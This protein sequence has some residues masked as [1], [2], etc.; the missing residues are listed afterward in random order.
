[1][2]RSA[3]ESRI[4]HRGADGRGAS[5]LAADR[6]RTGAGLESRRSV[7]DPAL[8]FYAYRLGREKLVERQVRFLAPLAYLS[9]RVIQAIAEGR[10]PADLTVTRLAR[11][12]LLCLDRAG[13]AARPR[14]IRPPSGPSKATKPLSRKRR[15]AARH[16][17]RGRHRPNATVSKKKQTRSRPRRLGNSGRLENLALET[18]RTK[19]AATDPILSVSNLRA[20]KGLRNTGPDDG[21]IRGSLRIPGMCGWGG[22]IRTS[23]WR[24]QNPLPYHLATP[25]HAARRAGPGGSGPDNSLRS[26][27]SQRLSRG[28]SEPVLLKPN[29]MQTRPDRRWRRR[30]E[31]PL[32]R[33]IEADR[34]RLRGR[35][36]P[37]RRP[38]RR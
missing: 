3:R 20:R 14:L 33:Q 27:A 10:A 5:P 15:C 25:Q 28:F 16:L 24:N 4:A 22:R 21:Y 1:M 29:L 37:P 7:K 32:A 9:P 19:T 13:R 38:A 36:R 11:N 18:G 23:G 17:R 6:H 8:D 26:S 12:L 2:H 34:R 31:R 35:R 30:P